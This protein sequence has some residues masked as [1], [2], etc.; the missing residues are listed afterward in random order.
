MSLQERL[1]RLDAH[2]TVSNEFR[3]YTAQGAALSVLT[4]C[5]ITYLVVSEAYF[6][7]QVEMKERVYV[8]A[9]SPRGLEM[10]FDISLHAVRCSELSIDA[11]DP[12]G[13]SLSLHLDKTHHV[14]KHRVL[15]NPKRPGRVKKVLGKRRKI[16]LGSTLL[17]LSDVTDMA[18]DMEATVDLQADP[19]ANSECGSCYG[20]GEPGE[21][22]NSCEDVQRAY[23]LKGWQLK[24][25]AEIAQCINEKKMSE[26]EGEGEG[27]NVHGTVALDSGGGN[28]HLAPGDDVA[29]GVAVTNPSFFDVLLQKFHEWNVTHTIHKLRFGPEYPAAIYQLDGQTRN[30]A[31]TH[32][33][34][35][36]YMQIVPTQYKFLNGTTIQTNQ[37]SV[38]EHL[39]H[40]NPGSNRGLPGVFFIY[41]LSPLH[42]EITEQYRKGWIAFFTSVCAVVGGVVT[43]MG[44]VDQFLFSKKTSSTSLGR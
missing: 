26:E 24:D 19:E 42:V 5:M 23:K 11:Q 25:P 3:V 17:E 35:Q 44:M 8:N 6:N 2:S 37:Y 38:T 9:T 22:C 41:E 10:E 36:Y 7:F 31:D 43:L 4:C 14:W 34:Y 29:S 40:V 32:G 13:Q 39:R 21:C 16:E 33:M 28:V 20:A 15:M 27:C 30:V 18:E 12:T 1:K